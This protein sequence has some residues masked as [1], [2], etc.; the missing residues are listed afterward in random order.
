MRVTQSNIAPD[1]AH[2][3]EQ[4]SKKL[5]A[6]FKRALNHADNLARAAKNR[7]EPL[8]FQL[9]NML[10]IARKQYE[11]IKINGHPTFGEGNEK[12][13]I[14]LV[15]ALVSTVDY[16]SHLR[17]SKG[18]PETHQKQLQQIVQANKATIA[19]YI[20]LRRLTKELEFTFS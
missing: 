6:K 18:L 10:E 20:H 14:S 15:A 2:P 12:D 4:D 13:R 9:Q 16:Y 5:I 17:H 8:S 1:Q 11:E 7:E 19:A 3:P